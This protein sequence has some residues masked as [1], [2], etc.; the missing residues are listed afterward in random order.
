M[1]EFVKPKTEIISDAD[2]IRKLVN[3]NLRKDLHSNEEICQ[4]CHGTGMIVVENRYGLSEDPDKSKGHFPYTH[5]SISFCP[6]CFNGIV[7][8]CPLCGKLIERGYSTCNCEAQK[9]IKKQEEINKKQDALNNAPIAPKEIVASMECFYSDN[10]STNDGY[11]Y[12]WEDFFE[13]WFEN[14]EPDMVKPEFVWCTEPIKISIDAQDIIEQ[15]TE[16][17]YEDASYDI[18]YEDRKELQDFLDSWCK[19]CGV[20]TTYYESHKYKVRIPWEESNS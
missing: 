4:H 1:S 5:Q 19:R 17:L 15:A 18:S 13:D 10:Y 3:V 14:N 20:A 7:H 9:E 12:D 2:Y 6:H 11:F 16:D 8:R